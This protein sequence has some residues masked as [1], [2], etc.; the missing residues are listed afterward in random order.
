M[1]QDN[2]IM[3]KDVF[4]SDMEWLEIAKVIDFFITKYGPQYS[5][6]PKDSG[7]GMRIYQND[8]G[9]DIG[10]DYN[11][12]TV[13]VVITNQEGRSL[14]GVVKKSV[15]DLGQWLKESVFL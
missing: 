1:T 15:N 5:L 9:L 8:I 12:T 13:H 11:G 6:L 3:I 14:D 2:T 4:F 7:P 10:F